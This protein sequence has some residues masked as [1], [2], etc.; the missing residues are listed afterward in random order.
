MRHCVISSDLGNLGGV[1]GYIDEQTLGRH[2][3]GLRPGMP[4]HQRDICRTRFG[5]RTALF[6]GIEA[7]K[8]DAVRLKRNGLVQRR[9]APGHAAL[10]VQD[11]HSPTHHSAGF[12]D[13]FVNAQH[14]TVTLIRGDEQHLFVCLGD[15]TTGRA[16]PGLP[17]LGR[18]GNSLFRLFEE[19]IGKGRC[20]AVQTDQGEQPGGQNMAK[21]RQSHSVLLQQNGKNVVLRF[22]LRGAT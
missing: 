13:T 8:D 18:G 5:D 11:T 15:R 17:G 6:T 4:T 14:T 20:R 1:G 10:A 2:C 16:V 12:A 9:G 7:A 19:G 21:I 3:P 22:V